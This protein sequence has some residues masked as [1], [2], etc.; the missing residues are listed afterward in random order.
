M[1]DNIRE[2]TDFMFLPFQ[3][4]FLLVLTLQMLSTAFIAYMLYMIMFSQLHRK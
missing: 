3:S 2:I 4:R 1:E